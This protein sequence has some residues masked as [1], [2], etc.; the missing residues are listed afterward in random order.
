MTSDSAGA[1]HRGQAKITD[2]ILCFIQLISAT[3]SY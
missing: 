2:R 3:L 1:P